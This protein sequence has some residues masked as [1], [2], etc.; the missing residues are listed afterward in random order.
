M[1]SLRRWADL[2]YP[3]T[4][5]F[6]VEMPIFTSPLVFYSLKVVFIQAKDVNV[7]GTPGAGARPIV[8]RIC[9][10]NPAHRWFDV[11]H[12]IRGKKVRECFKFD[13]FGKAVRFYGK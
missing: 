7:D 5:K 13:D 12:S 6:K 10:I 2:I 9:S 11:E 3:K 1:K 4:S 8:G